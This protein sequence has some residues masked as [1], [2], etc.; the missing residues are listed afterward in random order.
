M[1]P[2]ST[3]GSYNHNRRHAHRDR[4]RPCRLSAQGTPEADARSGS[5]TPSTTTAPTAKSRSTTRRSAPRSRARSPTAGRPR[6]RAR[7]QRAGRADRRQQ[8]ATAFAPRSATI[9][10]PRACRASTTTPTCCRWAAAWSRSA[11]P[12]RSWRS[13]SRRRSKAGRHQRRID[14]IAAIERGPVG[15]AR[16]PAGRRTAT[17]QASSHDRTNRDA[18]SRWRSLADDRPRGRP[19]DRQRA[20]SAEQRPRADRLGELRQ[21][22]GPRS[23]R[24]ACSRTSTPRAIPGKRYYGGCE[25]VDVAEPLAIDRA[26][27]LFGAEHANVQPHSGAQAN[28]AVYFAAA[29]AG[30]HRAGHEP[31]ARRPPH[32]RPSAEL[33]RQALHDRPLRRAAGRRADRLRRARAP[34]RTSTSRR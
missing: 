20:A 31:R 4:G 3:I 11:S 8:G 19:G 2:L 16:R 17:A 24:L 34:G 28:M 15:P 7:R 22:G 12:T 29:E 9:S 26:K 33:L 13:G 18:A 1:V 5:A 6:D 30:R 10:T 32:A 23:G 25:F 21:P 14:Q 27:Q